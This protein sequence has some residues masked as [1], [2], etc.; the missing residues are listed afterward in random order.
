M[1]VLCQLSY[2]GVCKFIKF[3]VYSLQFT[4][5]F[6]KK[7]KAK[8]GSFDFLLLSF[9]TRVHF[10][11]SFLHLFF[12]L[13]LCSN[14]LFSIFSFFGIHII[15]KSQIQSLERIFYWQTI[16]FNRIIEN[17]PAIKSLATIN[18]TPGTPAPHIKY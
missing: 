10:T 15:D 8:T 2:N 16:F 12:K 18:T 13:L 1:E 3:T 7:I 14:S 4:D 17:I 11:R 5:E 9:P 6:C